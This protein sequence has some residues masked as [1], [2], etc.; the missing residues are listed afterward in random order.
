MESIAQ[1]I[2]YSYQAYL[3]DTPPNEPSSKYEAPDGE[4]LYAESER[5][6]VAWEPSNPFD[7]SLSHQYS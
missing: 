5:T 7:E 6:D 4:K 2:I 3:Y 1:H